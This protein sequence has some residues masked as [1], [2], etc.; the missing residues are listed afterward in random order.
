MLQTPTIDVEEVIAGEE[1]E[2]NWM[3][4]YKNF[5]IRGVLPPNKDEAWHL[6]WKASYYAILSG[7]LLKRGLTTPLLKCLNSQ[8]VDY[9]MREIHEGTYGLHTGGRSLATKAVRVGYYWPTLKADALDFTR[10]CRRC[11]EFAD[12]PCTPPNN[13]HSLNFPCPFAK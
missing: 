3:T 1:E 10:R 7:E 12:M 4:P 2:L 5:L 8:Q 6:K 9:V 13:L 11:Q